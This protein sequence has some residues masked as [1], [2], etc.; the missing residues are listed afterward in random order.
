MDVMLCG[1]T[2]RTLSAHCAEPAGVKGLPA[3]HIPQ[4][5]GE[6]AHQGHNN[7]LLVTPPIGLYLVLK[8]RPRRGLRDPV[9]RSAQ[10]LPLRR[11]S[12]RGPRLLALPSLHRYAPGHALA[13]ACRK[14]PGRARRVLRDAG[15]EMRRR[16]ELGPAP[17]E[18]VWR[19]DDDRIPPEPVLVGGFKVL[20]SP[21]G[22]G[23]ALVFVARN[24]SRRADAGG[25]E[26]PVL[27]TTWYRLCLSVY[28]S[29]RDR[30]VSNVTGPVAAAGLG[31]EGPSLAT[32]WSSASPV[33][34]RHLLGS[35]DRGPAAVL[36]ARLRRTPL[37]FRVARRSPLPQDRR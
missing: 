19:A 26:S 31:T 18:Q 27:S 13:G 9:Q 29:L 5:A 24:I 2:G 14:T 17:L 21:A 28:P 1:G 23:S 4:G 32:S 36:R 35:A 6:F 8:P 37:H 10:D 30:A 7:P 25:P 16:P 11:L 12:H 20:K 3:C 33:L 34:H 22:S 15:W